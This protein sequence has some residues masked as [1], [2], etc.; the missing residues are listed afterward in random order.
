MSFD[1]HLELSGLCLLVRRSTELLVLL[2]RTHDGPHKHW[3]VL[4]SP[5]GYQPDW[6]AGPGHRE[7]GYVY[8]H[9]GGMPI[10]FATE[11]DDPSLN[12]NFGS[13]GVVDL[14]CGLGVQPQEAHVQ[15]TL[16]H[17]EP[18]RQGNHLEGVCWTRP[19]V[20]KNPVMRISTLI[21]WK[22]PELKNMIAPGV[23]GLRIR[24][25]SPDEQP[26]DVILRPDDKNV[27]KMF[28]FNTLADELPWSGAEI[29]E[30]LT[31][32]QEARHF[33]HYLSLLR[34]GHTCSAPRYFGK[35]NSSS[36]CEPD[37]LSPDKR[38]DDEAALPFRSDKFGRRYSCVLATTEG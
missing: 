20:S 33:H 27:V 10:T 11:P 25:S 32:G 8:H 6:S 1:L 21:T 14:G 16:P 13:V 37:P 23:S 5:E 17:G 29:T 30:K 7:K 28:L 26:Y 31:P 12:T 2:P 38:T 22:I 15:I 19:W 18:Y 9:L 35:G 34:A 4:G 3:P 36:T 24:V